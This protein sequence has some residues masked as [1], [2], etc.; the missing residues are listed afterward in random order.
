[1]L[2]K[3]LVLANKQKNLLTQGLGTVCLSITDN[4]TLGEATKCSRLHWLYTKSIVKCIIEIDH[5]FKGTQ[6]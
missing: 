4:A 6:D 1:M 3:H 2:L 5:C